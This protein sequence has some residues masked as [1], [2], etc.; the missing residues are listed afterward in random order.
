[1]SETRQVPRCDRCG[2]AMTFPPEYCAHCGRNRCPQCAEAGCCGREPMEG[3]AFDTKEPQPVLHVAGKMV[4]GGVQKCSRCDEV[5]SDYRNT[6]A[7]EGT[8]APTGFR[9][10]LLVVVTEDVRGTV[11]ETGLLFVDDRPIP[12]LCVP[13]KHLRWD[14]S[15][16][17]GTC[18]HCGRYPAQGHA[19]DCKGG[20]AL[21]E[22][23]V[24][25]HLEQMRVMG[26]AE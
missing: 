5:L 17:L 6:M 1:M 3:S 13:G 14:D 4:E 23:L 7:P 9:P 12:P 2:T 15:R 18:L 21:K 26:L 25:E 24:R 20:A 10:G 11:R 19:E 8:P 16:M 22:R